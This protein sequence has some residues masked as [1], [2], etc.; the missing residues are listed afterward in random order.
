AIVAAI[1]I[2]ARKLWT[3]FL[4]QVVIAQPG[5]IRLAVIA[6]KVLA[7]IPT[8]PI[9]VC[10]HKNNPLAVRAP[11]GRKESLALAKNLMLVAAVRVDQ[12]DA[13]FATYPRKNDL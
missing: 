2:D 12:I 11:L 13:I 6:A 1:H 8:F 7:D 3:V 9:A 10:T 4:D 5:C